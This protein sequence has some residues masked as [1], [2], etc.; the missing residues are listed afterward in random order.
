MQKCRKWLHRKNGGGFDQHGP[1]PRKGASGSMA[2]S[3][4]RSKSPNGGRGPQRGGK[5]RGGNAKMAADGANMA[6]NGDKR[7]RSK[8]KGSLSKAADG[9]AAGFNAPRPQ[10]KSSG[11]FRSR[12]DS[13]MATDHYS[14]VH[15]G[16]QASKRRRLL[17]VRERDLAWDLAE[18]GETSSMAK[19]SAREDGDGESAWTSR[20]Q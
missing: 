2:A 19:R 11:Q 5:S 8:G 20:R 7:R 13:A 15:S 16:E 18:E 4:K 17:V 9:E 3:F 1:G 12:D 14:A 6:E 10:L